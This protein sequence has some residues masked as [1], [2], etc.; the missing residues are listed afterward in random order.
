[1]VGDEGGPFLLA[2]FFFSIFCD[3]TLGKKKSP[4][5]PTFKKLI[6]WRKF[7]NLGKRKQTTK[8]SLK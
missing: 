4:N 7:E 8:Q 6:K 3:F 2:I 1:M 5:F